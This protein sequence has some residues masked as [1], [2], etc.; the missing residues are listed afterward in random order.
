AGAAGHQHQRQPERVLT[1]G[2]VAGDHRRTSYPAPGVAPPESPDI[3][4]AGWANV[5][6]LAAAAR[7][8]TYASNTARRRAA[9]ARAAGGSQVTYQRLNQPHF[10]GVSGF[11][12]APLGDFADVGPGAV[13][14]LGAPHDT[15][16]SSRQ[17]ARFGPRG[18]RQASQYLGEQF[19]R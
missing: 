15:T 12:R 6:P 13:T 16:C 18:I 4:P 1:P 2:D 14:I 7:P 19:A 17:G 3:R 10:A 11:L 5:P 8:V 9:R